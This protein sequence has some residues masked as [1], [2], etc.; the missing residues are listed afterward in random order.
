MLTEYLAVEKD[1]TV[2]ERES[3]AWAALNIGSFRVST[4]NEA[5]EVAMKKQFYYIGINASNVNYES[6]LELLRATTNDPIFIA[7]DN[8]TMQEQGRAIQLGAD[9]FG[10]LGETP[11]D[12]IASVTAQ[13]NRLND[14]AK[15]RKTPPEITIVRNL[16]MAPL[17]HKAFIY[18]T[19][20]DLTKTE[21]D[22]LW[23]LLQ[24]RGIVLKHDQLLRRIG[25]KNYDKAASD[26]VLWNHMGRIKQKLAE[27]AP[28]VDYIENIKG[29][30]YRFL[31]ECK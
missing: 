17:Y 3:K 27:V 19:P 22:V 13:I 31:H 7:T 11:E 28:D 23:Y 14:R 15:H 6:K 10:Q 26:D 4:M 29:V 8:Y 16:L 12:N 25:G 9:L 2:Q 24:N 5:I 1:M 21:F 30:G 18:E 20:I